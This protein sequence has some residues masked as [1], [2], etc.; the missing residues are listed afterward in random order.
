MNNSNTSTNISTITSNFKFCLTVQ[1][2]QSHS[3]L[4][5]IDKS[6]LLRI[7][8]AEFPGVTR[9]SHQPTNSIKALK[10]YKSKNKYRTT[11]TS[12]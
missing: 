6:E 4:G 10:S 8:E 7:V 2:F 3:R 9:H 1:F 12:S 11:C 5:Q